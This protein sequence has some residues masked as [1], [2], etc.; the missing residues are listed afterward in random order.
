MS[1]EKTKKKYRTGCIVP[2]GLYIGVLVI[3]FFVTRPPLITEDFAGQTARS[4]SVAI[5]EE[6]DAGYEYG[7]RTL[8]IIRG[9][10]PELPSFGFLLPE[11]R[12][13]INV[14]DIH[15]AAIIE[16]HGDWQLIEFNYS[17]TYMATS[18][19]RAYADRIEPVSYQVTSSVGDVM[20]AVAVTI[21]AV[22]LY[23]LAWLVNFFR[24]RRAS[25]A[26]TSQID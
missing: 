5:V 16:D 24:N 15:H 25:K 20:M 14:G 4:F 17:N 18:I 1:F 21:V 3:G 23:L 8:E 12:I 2:L 7:R 10:D 11:Q 6:A 13:T 26:V 19:Y 22:L 9:R